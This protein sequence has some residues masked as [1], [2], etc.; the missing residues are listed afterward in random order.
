M[1]L[2]EIDRPLMQGGFVVKGARCGRFVT[3]HHSAIRGM[4]PADL[5]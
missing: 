5:S 4:L 1:P 3:I 2:R